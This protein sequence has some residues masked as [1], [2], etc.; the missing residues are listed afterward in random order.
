[1]TAATERKAA[2]DKIVG[3][4]AAAAKGAADAKAAAEKKA[5]D[6]TAAMQKA[7]ELA[8]VAD[9]AAQEAAAKAKAAAEAKAEAEKAAAEAEAQAKAA[10]DAKA[11]AE[12]AAAETEAKS[13]EA[14]AVQQA[15]AK[16]VTDATNKA[17][18][19]N[20]NLAAPSPTV[21]LKVTPAPITMNVPPAG[22]TVKQGATL[23]LPLA[24]GR[25]YGFGD[26]VQIKTK[27]PGGLAGVKVADVSIPAGAAEG[28][29]VVEVAKDPPVGTHKLGVTAVSKY[30]GQDLSVEQSVNITIEAAQ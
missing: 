21:T 2:V 17:K 3:E 27:L 28:K 15:V 1:M 4:L 11:I 30:N 13:K 29:L 22:S 6:M 5:A 20:I 7:R 14:A 12:K 19:A 24:I 23:E 9:K 26:A 16:A 10:A 8:Q 25:L 18:P